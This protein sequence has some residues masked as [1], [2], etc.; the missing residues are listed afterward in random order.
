[1]RKIF[2]SVIIILFSLDITAQTA[3]DYRLAAEN[4]DMEAQFN[5]GRCYSEGWG[6]DKDETVALGWYLISAKQG[7][8][9]AH[10]V[11]TR[12][13]MTGNT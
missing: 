10:I 3:D 1:M 2:S 12:K 7:H 11:Y 5:L 6:V 8:V 9:K 13:M 4:G